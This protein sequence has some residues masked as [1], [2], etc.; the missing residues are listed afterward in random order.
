ML[1]NNFQNKYYNILNFVLYYFWIQSFSSLGLLFRARFRNFTFHG[2][3]FMCFFIIL[4]LGLWPLHKW[5][6]YIG[7][8]IE[9]LILSIYLTFQ[10]IPIILFFR[11]T[12]YKFL[13]YF[14]IIN[15]VIGSVF[16]IWSKNLKNLLLR[17]SIYISFWTIVLIFSS[18]I[19]TL[20]FYVIYFLINNLIFLT[21]IK[22]KRSEFNWMNLI[23]IFLFFIGL[24]PFSMFFIKI[25]V[26]KN[27]FIISTITNLLILFFCFIR[28]VGY[29]KFFFNF[30][31]PFLKLYNNNLTKKHIKILYL[32]IFRFLFLL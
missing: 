27:F 7:Y 28:V 24:P 2:N 19:N 9:G 5:F 18:I 12:E 17:S 26:L 22:L 14:F 15:M 31:T 1:S 6:F 10:K 25:I 4:K 16:I 20:V 11:I 23:I 30:L 29:F 32:F 21:K 8:S 13:L 3:F